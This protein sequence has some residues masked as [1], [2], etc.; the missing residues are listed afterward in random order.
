M[1]FDDDAR[2]DSLDDPHLWPRD[3]RSSERCLGDRELYRHLEEVGFTGPVY[4]AF[5]HELV[6][7]GYHVVTGLVSSGKMFRLCAEQGFRLGGAPHAW[8]RDDRVELALETTAAA[9]QM[10]RKRAIAGD[11][12]SPEGG[13]ALTTYFVKACIRVFP[14]VYRMWRREWDRWN[15]TVEPGADPSDVHVHGQQGGPDPADVVSTRDA[16][17]RGLRDL[18][19]DT[20]RI[21]TLDSMGFSH[22]EIGEQTQRTPRAVEGVLRRHRLRRRARNGRAQGGNPGVGEEGSNDGT[23]RSPRPSGES[24][25][26]GSARTR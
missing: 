24:P 7:Y 6:Q 15:R 19:R 12:W 10:F 1:E 16:L 11:G 9:L 20:A 2:G 17:E 26:G 18:S 21:V 13:A 22:R 8:T 14:G 25:A 5:A 4:D 3:P 23:H